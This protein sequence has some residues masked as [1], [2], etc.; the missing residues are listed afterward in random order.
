[1]TGRHPLG[2]VA[3]LWRYPVKGLAAEPLQRSYVGPAGLAGDRGAALFV[4]ADGHARSGKTFRGKEHNLLHT[5]AGAEDA[6]D[7]AAAR[8]VA[9]E[10]RADGPHFDDAPVSVIF[11]RWLAEAED[12]LGYALDP[13]RFRPNLFVA[14]APDFSTLEAD[15]IGVRLRAGTTVLRVVAPIGRCI[16]TTYDLATGESDPDVLRTVARFRNNIMGVYCEVE[17]PGDVCAGDLV[18]NEPTG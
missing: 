14:A 13:L 12:L 3:H 1:M 15:L 6:V 18:V 11:D 5:V 10:L 16:T 2:S 9:V 17:V 7:L 4:T 8:G